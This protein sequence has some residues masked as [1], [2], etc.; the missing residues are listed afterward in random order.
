M[1]W[2][3]L[4]LWRATALESEERKAR[5]RLKD[6]LSQRDYDTLVRVKKSIE[7]RIDA[8]EDFYLHHV[9]DDRAVLFEKHR[10]KLRKL[11]QDLDSGELERQAVGEQQGQIKGTAEGIDSYRSFISS[12]SADKR[13]SPTPQSQSGTEQ[14]DQRSHYPAD[15]VSTNTQQQLTPDVVRNYREDSRLTKEQMLAWLEHV[16]RQVMPTIDDELASAVYDQLTRNSMDDKM[17]IRELRSWWLSFGRNG[18]SIHNLYPTSKRD[19]QASKEN[20]IKKSRARTSSSFTN[21]GLYPWEHPS[22]RRFESSTPTHGV[23]GLEDFGIQEKAID[24]AIELTPAEFKELQ[25]RKRR[26]H[27]EQRF[28]ERT[29]KS[30]SRSGSPE[31]AAS[32]SREQQQTLRESTPYFEPSK[33]EEWIF[34]SPDP[35]KW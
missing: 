2:P 16:G 30:R 33:L 1:D 26:H 27:A 7:A 21:Q 8:L 34:R 23:S 10:M 17:T 18:A 31:P 32:P 25:L 3:E 29:H 12:S 19:A 11:L 5:Q 35:N 22:I 9:E 4:T 13:R 28:M 14:Q 15:L 24:F 6:L 20:A